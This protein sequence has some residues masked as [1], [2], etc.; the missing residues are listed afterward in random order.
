MDTANAAKNIRRLVIS[1]GG[2]V[3]L[4]YL[5]AIAQLMRDGKLV[6]VDAICAT[7]VGA[8]VGAFFCIQKIQQKQNQ[9]D[10]KQNFDTILH[11]IV[12]RP[13][14]GVFQLSAE[15]IMGAFANKGVYDR[16]VIMQ[17]L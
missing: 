7:S 11:Y 4:N 16:S 5:G 1:G 3:G 9:K 15:Q 17:I 6:H 8:I 12:T 13:W 10:E 14:T 2:I